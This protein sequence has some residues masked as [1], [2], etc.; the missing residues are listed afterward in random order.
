MADLLPILPFFVAAILTL[1]T[2]G[3][4][5]A[6]IMLGTPFIA[7]Y[8]LYNL[9]T[10][11]T[12]TA[13]LMGFEMM[14][15]RIDKLSMLF[16][17]LF[18]I[19]ALLGNI[20]A[21]YHK[22][23]LQHFAAQAYAGSAIGAVLAG[24]MLTLFIYWELMALTSS[25]LIFAR[26]S[27][28]SFHAGIRYLVMQVISGLLLLAGIIIYYQSVGNLDFNFIGLDSPGGWLIF[29]AFGIKSAFPLLHNWLTD[30]YPE[31]TASGTVFL[32]SFTTKV[33]VYALARSFA[34]EEIMIYIGAVMAFFPIYYAVIE[35]D[36]RRV[37]TYS[38]INQV[39]FMIVGI[40]IGTELALNGAVGHAF[41][42]VIFK[43]LLMMS[44]GAVLHSTGEMRGSELGGLY[45]RMPKTTFFAIIGAASIS[46]FPLFSGF[47]TKSMIVSAVL[48]EGYY[49]VWLVLLFAAAGVFHHAGIKIPYFAFFAHD[50]K[51]IETAK[52]APNPM[53]WAMAL[54]SVFCI[55]IGVFPEAFY[56][57][58]PWPM[59]Y[60][61]YDA[62]HVLAQLQLLFFSALAFVWL[63]L[64]GI[65]PPELKSVNLDA[66]WVYRR[67]F[68]KAI[69]SIGNVFSALFTTLE[70]KAERFVQSTQ[71][72]ATQ[73]LG[74]QGF[75]SNFRSL[76]G[77]VMWVAV[78]LSTSLFLYYL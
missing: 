20:Y 25:V 24:D 36:L 71:S 70:L 17:Y 41:A 68:P 18:C 59:E 1:F 35:N 52:E 39:G 3:W 73:F 47:V 19:A 15:I 63:Q 62:T 50:S 2:R 11:H 5:R 42:D 74:P 14:P 6:A 60:S 43:G 7:A 72:T 16:G 65:Y 64:A 57:M 32:S 23:T 55:A 8:G 37:L 9:D 69:Y 67:V 27:E 58:M 30:A 46:A 49:G 4:L 56:A 28:A 33:A 61:P 29:L 45:K 13:T 26:R 66:E 77:M 53:L 34:G 44:M 76:G 21:L 54:S 78:I 38:L 22:D 40:G 51:H 31:A 10:G 75:L 12:V 48:M